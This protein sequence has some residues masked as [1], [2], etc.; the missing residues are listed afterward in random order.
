MGGSKMN[1]I[2]ILL[3]TL[4]DGIQSLF[5]SKNYDDILF[6]FLENSIEEIEYASTLSL[7][8]SI[9]DTK[10]LHHMAGTI[11]H[12]HFNWIKNSYYLSYF[13]YWRILELDNFNNL[14]ELKE[15]ISIIDEPDYDMIEDNSIDFV[16]DKIYALTNNKN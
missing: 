3:K 5:Q 7:I 11:Y 2:N 1:S 4:P 14:E 10:E 12:F 8:A 13:H 16:R 9:A 6:Y 15:F